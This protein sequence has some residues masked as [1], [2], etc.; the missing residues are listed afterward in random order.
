MEYSFDLIKRI[1][2]FIFPGFRYL[3]KRFSTDLRPWISVSIHILIYILQD[4]R[5]VGIK[6]LP[7]IS[8]SL[9]LMYYSIYSFSV[10]AFSLYAMTFLRCEYAYFSL[11]CQVLDWGVGRAEDTALRIPWCLNCSG[12]A[13]LQQE[14]PRLEPQACQHDED[15]F[16]HLLKRF[17]FC[18]QRNKFLHWVR[19]QGAGG[20]NRKLLAKVLSFL[21]VSKPFWGK[22]YFL[23]YSSF[24]C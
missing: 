1:K 12:E 21:L 10:T 17:C 2:Y 14:W 3:Y 19:L 16:S 13:S 18:F 15:T 7:R 8:V 23:I 6:N 11:S 20:S 5:N 22:D 9:K 24:G 4:W